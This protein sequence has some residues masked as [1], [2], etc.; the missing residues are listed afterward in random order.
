MGL[1]EGYSWW[2]G[3]G[4][5]T[6]EC[7]LVFGISVFLG[8]HLVRIGG[9]GEHLRR[10]PIGRYLSSSD[11]HGAQAWEV[12][13][14]SRVE[15]GRWLSQKA[16]DCRPDSRATCVGITNNMREFLGLQDSFY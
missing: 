12:L 8:V 2:G 3:K 7:C 1:G 9:G 14:R 5:T 4:S 10:Y 6:V 16:L 11:G 15:T 13:N